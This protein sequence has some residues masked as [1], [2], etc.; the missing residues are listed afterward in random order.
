MARGISD[1]RREYSE[2]LKI[3]MAIVGAGSSHRL[4]QHR[5]PAAGSLD[6]TGARTGSAAGARRSQIAHHPPASHR[7]PAACARGRSAGH[8]FRR[9]GQ[10]PS[11]A[12]DFARVPTLFLSMSRSTC[13]LL[14]FTFAVT[15][16]TALLFGTLPALRATRLQLT[17]SLKSGRGASLRRPDAA[18]KNT[19]RLAGGA[20][21]GADGGRVPFPAHT[22]QSEPCRYWLQQGECTSSEYRLNPYWLQGR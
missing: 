10:P 7:E 15:V 6:R 8:W 2:P 14:A 13:A 16:C 1:L 12:H 21:A 22:C 18:G 17:E 4:R 5:Q 20:F 9:C 19:R 11:S 3:L